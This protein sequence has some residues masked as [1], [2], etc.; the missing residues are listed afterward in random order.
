[1]GDNFHVLANYA[2]MRF[3]DNF[4]RFPSGLGPT[5]HTKNLAENYCGYIRK[6]VEGCN[7]VK[8][9]KV[10]PMILGFLAIQYIVVHALSE[11]WNHE[12]VLLRTAGTF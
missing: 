3:H 2:L 7:S 11:C 5:T 6:F 8:F 1:M 12:V 9:A 10:S 4:Y